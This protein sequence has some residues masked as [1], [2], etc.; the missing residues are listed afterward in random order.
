MEKKPEQIE[1]EQWLKDVATELEVKS[2][3]PEEMISCPRCARTSPP[4]RLKCFYCGADLPITETQAQSISPQL[5]KLE[6]WEKGFNLIL[7]PREKEIDD[8]NFAVVKKATQLETEDL[9]KMLEAKTALPL[10]RAESRTEIQ[11]IQ[12]KIAEAG[13]ESLIVSDENLRPETPV[14]RLRRIELETDKLILVLFNSDEVVE[15][16]REDLALIV[17]GASFERR[18][19]STER[20]KKRVNK[21]LE[22]METTADEILVDFYA[23]DDSVGYRINSRG[24]DFSGLENEKGILARENMQKLVGKLRLFAPAATFV[25][26]YLIIRE[27]LGKVWEVEQKKDSRGLQRKSFGRF[28]LGNVTTTGNLAQFTKYS[29]LQRHLL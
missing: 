27:I 15:M 25:E 19:E 10:A 12:K 6:S 13:Y 24:F 17:V 3:K 22:T 5:R 21:V 28:E 7:L 14:R 18:V 29:R 20:R 26:N 1:T 2:F 11:I 16:P 23:K 9:R 4:T 8:E